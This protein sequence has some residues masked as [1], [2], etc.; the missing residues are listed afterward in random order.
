MVSPKE[1][2]SLAKLL[3]TEAFARQGVAPGELTVHSDR[4]APMT[5][6]L[7]TQ[8]L[9]DLGVTKSFSRPRVSNDNPYSESHFKTFKNRPGY[10]EK[11]GSSQD[12]HS[13]CRRFFAWYNNDHRH[14]GIGYLPPAE[15]HAG[16]AGTIQRVRG[17]LLS[18]A[19]LRT[20][21]RFVNG[22]P[23]PPMTPTEAWINSPASSI[24]VAPDGTT[25]DAKD[26]HE[27]E[28]EVTALH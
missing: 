6:K 16:R 25:I 26:E 28:E 3:L 4:G 2:G 18:E 23:M 22:M 7:L 9:A 19:F 8:K 11:F 14:A 13:F 5:S 17:D 1:T 20:P 15:V 10:P 12:A 27:V 24:L 21:E